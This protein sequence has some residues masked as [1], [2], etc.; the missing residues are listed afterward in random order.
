M[1]P[2]SLFVS[3]SA[4]QFTLPESGLYE[5]FFEKDKLREIDPG[6]KNIRKDMTESTIS[7]VRKTI[8]FVD[9][10]QKNRYSFC[11]FAETKYKGAKIVLTFRLICDTTH[12]KQ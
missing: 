1:A 9:R 2:S 12:E 10:I 4:K 3:L 5:P 8:N 11:N 6:A 7:M